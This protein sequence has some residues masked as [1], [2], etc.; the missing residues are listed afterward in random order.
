[1]EQDEEAVFGSSQQT[2]ACED[3]AEVKTCDTDTVSNKV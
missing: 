3:P 2:A 1:M